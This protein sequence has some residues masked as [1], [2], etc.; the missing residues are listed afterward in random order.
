[1]ASLI[2]KRARR[3]AR[4]GAQSSPA[5]RLMAIGSSVP[6]PARRTPP[7]VAMEAGIMTDDSLDDIPTVP[8][9]LRETTP[10]AGGAENSKAFADF[11]TATEEKFRQ[12]ERGMNELETRLAE[13][14]HQVDKNLNSFEPL[15]KD[16]GVFTSIKNYVNK[17]EMEA[18]LSALEHLIR[19]NNKKIEG[20]QQTG[21]GKL[22]QLTKQTEQ[23]LVK[24]DE[25][26]KKLNTLEQDFKKHLEVNFITVEEECKTIRSILN[27]VMEAANKSSEANFTTM[28]VQQTQMHRE[29]L[30][31]KKSSDLQD[32]TNLKHFLDFKNEI[33]QL[34]T[35]M[36]SMQEH[37]RG[38]AAGSSQSQ[39]EIYMA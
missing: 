36:G 8:P 35:G 23:A 37:I 4:G 25:H 32:A 38:L 31:N 6:S 12:M 19:E 11:K 5:S 1:M 15:R 18:K 7:P 26:F 9:G 2:P 20:N 34:Q 27:E 39:T 21:D 29:L 22:A 17:D 30:A 14:L 3:S 16:I 10:W 33:S 28:Q 24:I 13:K